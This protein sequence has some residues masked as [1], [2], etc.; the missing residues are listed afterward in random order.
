MDAL[1]FDTRKDW[2]QAVK[3]HA[4]RI[5]G[6]IS[7]QVFGWNITENKDA[8]IVAVYLKGVEEGRKNSEAILA[9]L[10]KKYQPTQ[11]EQ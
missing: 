4:S 10:I 8:L 1:K 2:E 3:H 6:M 11:K 5:L 7:H 9:E